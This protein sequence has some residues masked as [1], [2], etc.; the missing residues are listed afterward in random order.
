[1]GLLTGKYRPESVLP[2][3]DVRGPNAPDWMKYFK[4][5]Q[6]NPEWLNKVH[7]I[8]EILRSGGRT[9]AQGALAWLWTRSEKTLPIPGF[10]TLAQVEENCGALD[11]GLLTPEQMRQIDAILERSMVTR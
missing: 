6:P 7:T 8:R 3:D 9:L 10:R 11:F 1:M 4:D 2:D 5:G